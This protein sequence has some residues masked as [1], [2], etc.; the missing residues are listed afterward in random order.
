[1]IH[2]LIRLA[3]D[4]IVAA[5]LMQPSGFSPDHSGLF[6]QNN[7]TGWGPPLCENRPDLNMEIVHDFLLAC[8]RT[9]PISF[10]RLPAITY[11]RYKHQC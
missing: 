5:A 8:I 4:R 7:I 9:K 1:M 6:Y 2:N 11:A 3:P 10:S